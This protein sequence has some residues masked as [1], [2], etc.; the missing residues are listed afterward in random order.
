[1]KNS[2]EAAQKS[3]PLSSKTRQSKKP[4][5]PAVLPTSMV[6]NTQT[7][8]SR[9]DFLK[10]RSSLLEE[11]SSDPHHDRPIHHGQKTPESISRLQPPLED[12]A[13]RCKEEERKGITPDAIKDKSR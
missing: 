11:A 1:M 6:A 10:G 12:A 2:D 13:A 8:C 9:S 4:S 5:P 3:P 7:E